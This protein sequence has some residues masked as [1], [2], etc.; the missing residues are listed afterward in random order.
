MITITITQSYND[1]H[2]DDLKNN[3]RS[4]WGLM[5]IIL[6]LLLL[7]QSQNRLPKSRHTMVPINMIIT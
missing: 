6:L 1:E 7:E 5:V 2:D 4:Y 3:E